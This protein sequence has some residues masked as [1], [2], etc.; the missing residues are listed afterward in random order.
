[1]S[2]FLTSCRGALAS[3]TLG[4]AMEGRIDAPRVND[5]LPVFL[6]DIFEMSLV[7]SIDELLLLVVEPM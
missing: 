3:A 2:G 6:I 5:F 1:M 7:L 4:F